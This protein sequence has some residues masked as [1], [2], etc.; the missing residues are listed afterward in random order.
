MGIDIIKHHRI[1]QQELFFFSQVLQ[2]VH[3][4]FLLLEGSS[5]G[6]HSLSKGLEGSLLDL[7]D[8]GLVVFKNLL[9]VSRETAD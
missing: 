5:S 1:D 2:D 8:A 7:L 9:L 3:E 4:S 6:S